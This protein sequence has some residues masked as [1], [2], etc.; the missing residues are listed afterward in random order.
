ML[1]HQFSDPSHAY[2]VPSS[3]APHEVFFQILLAIF[4]KKIQGLRL[5]LLYSM[6][7]NIFAGEYG[8]TLKELNHD[9]AVTASEHQKPDT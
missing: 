5:F 6:N 1:R 3:P 4:E 9:G 2:A 7:S 8:N